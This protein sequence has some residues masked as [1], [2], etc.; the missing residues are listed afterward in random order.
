VNRKLI[1]PS[2]TDI[3]EQFVARQ[4]RKKPTPPES[5]NAENFYY[6]KQMQSRTPMVV[7][8]QDGEQIHGVIEWYDRSCI[9]VNRVKEPN[10]LIYKTNIK[11]IYKENEPKPSPGGPPGGNTSGSIGGNTNPQ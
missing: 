2:L 9:K 3:K 7:V 11:Y 1:R 5:T 10:L 4:P 6:V 8:L